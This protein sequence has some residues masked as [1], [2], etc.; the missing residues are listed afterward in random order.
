MIYN[1][2]CDTDVISGLIKWENECWSSAYTYHTQTQLKTQKKILG[3]GTKYIHCEMESLKP[4]K[5]LFDSIHKN[6]SIDIWPLL[7]KEHN[8][9]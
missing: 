2:M 8:N 3:I 4:S 6:K 7:L 9:G 1:L 5:G